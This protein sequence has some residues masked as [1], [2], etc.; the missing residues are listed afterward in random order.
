MPFPLY[1]HPIGGVLYDGVLGV[2]AKDG[3]PLE[4]G[5]MVVL[6]VD[7]ETRGRE[8]TPKTLVSASSV[9]YVWGQQCQ[10]PEGFSRGPGELL[11]EI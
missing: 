10:G 7:M 1:L 2:G 9:V 8:S 11:W 6:G 4:I 5:I 3:S